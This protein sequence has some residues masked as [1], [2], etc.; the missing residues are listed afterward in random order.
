MEVHSR[1]R[2]SSF[3]SPI[4]YEHEMSSD[5]DIIEMISILF[6][7]LV[8]YLPYLFFLLELSMALAS[9]LSVVSSELKPYQIK[10]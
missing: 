4:K 6:S 10:N 5:Q 8:F 3:V 1:L 7:A 9:C 2:H